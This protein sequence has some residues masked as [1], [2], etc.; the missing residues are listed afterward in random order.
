[1]SALIDA[2]NGQEPKPNTGQPAVQPQILPVKFVHR[3]GKAYHEIHADGVWGLLNGHGNIQANF[4]IEHPPI[5]NSVVFPLNPN[6]TFSQPVEEYKEK[7][8]KHFIVIR[9]FQVGVV[10]SLAAAKQIHTVLGNFIAVADD[11]LMAV[12]QMKAKTSITK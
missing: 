11:Q 8:E 1:M 2:M 5:P 7:D 4:F 9:E 3:E 6:G 10:M 12:E